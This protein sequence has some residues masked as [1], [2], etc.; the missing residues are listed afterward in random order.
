MVT[1]L[2][3]A[4][5]VL[6]TAAHPVLS[7]KR[8]AQLTA[9]LAGT[10]D[11]PGLMEHAQRHGVA[12]ILHGHLRAMP[13][14]TVP[15]DVTDTLQ[16]YADRRVE[17]LARADLDGYVLKADSPSCGLEGPGLFA[18]VLTARMPELPIVDERQL[19]DGHARQR[20]AD[21]PQPSLQIA[22]KTS[23]QQFANRSRTRLWSSTE[24]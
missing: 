11:W 10:V 9:L 19:D 3:G 8:Q 14:V 6:V 24:M 15:R 23:A 12:P 20:F 1:P 2:E 4:D 5:L 17:E 13:T 16:R 21:V 7:P 18:A 22:V